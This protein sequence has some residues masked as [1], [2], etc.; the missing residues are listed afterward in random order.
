MSKVL[1]SVIL[2]FA[3][4][5]AMAQSQTSTPQP[6]PVP[7]GGQRIVVQDCKVLP[8]GMLWCRPRR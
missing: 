3:A 2:V 8:N 4:T 6:L 1:I 5:E 7:N